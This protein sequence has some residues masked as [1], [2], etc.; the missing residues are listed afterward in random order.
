M[1]DKNKEKANLEKKVSKKEYDISEVFRGVN[2]SKEDIGNMYR[3]AIGN[4]TEARERLK[5][6]MDRFKGVEKEVASLAK[7]VEYY[8]QKLNT[9]LDIREAKWWQKGL[10]QTTK[11]IPI[12]K[13]RKG[14]QEKLADS[15]KNDVI[16][17]IMES[18]SQIGELTTT[19][20][21]LIKDGNIEHG[22]LRG[23]AH[24]DYLN[25]QEKAVKKMNE[26]VEKINGYTENLDEIKNNLKEIEGI[27]D[28]RKEYLTLKKERGELE[29]ALFEAKQQLVKATIDYNVAEDCFYQAEVMMDRLKNTIGIMDTKNYQV[30]QQTEQVAKLIPGM[31][32]SHK[33]VEAGEALVVLGDQ[34]TDV[35]RS[36]AYLEAEKVKSLAQI[37][38]TDIETRTYDPVHKLQVELNE[39]TRKIIEATQAYIVHDARS[40]MKQQM[41]EQLKKEVEERNEIASAGGDPIKH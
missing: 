19:V 26:Y 31:L 22:N 18:M 2:Y 39:E 32:A 16:D 1:V 21:G 34:M 9:G 8:G 29:D 35:L 20:D 38:G 11:I 41:Y 36:Q 25:Q 14:A 12:K 10:Y 30:A 23:L 17:I 15:Q 4:P 33:L 37:V 13:W 28:K 3:E 40:G 6:D 27:E 7:N 5:A 24:Q